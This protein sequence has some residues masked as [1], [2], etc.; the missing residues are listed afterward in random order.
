MSLQ[1]ILETVANFTIECPDGSI[2]CDKF[3]MI[4]TSSLIRNM[5]EEYENP[6]SVSVPVSKHSIEDAVKVIHGIASPQQICSTVEHCDTLLRALDFL[7]VD[8]P[9][10]FNRNDTY[11]HFCVLLRKQLPQTPKDALDYLS[12]YAHWF[13]ESHL[14]ATNFVNILSTRT[15]LFEDFKTVL[16]PLDIS[17]DMM[18]FLTRQFVARFPTVPVIEFFIRKIPLS[19][20]TTSTMIT[21]ATGYGSPGVYVHPSELFRIYQGISRSRKKLTDFSEDTWNL[22]SFAT[23]ATSHIAMGDP[24]GGPA[25]TGLNFPRAVPRATFVIEGDFHEYQFSVACMDEAL[26]FGINSNELFLVFDERIL[27]HRYKNIDVRISF[28]MKPSGDTR[29][30]REA[31]YHSKDLD[32]IYT[33][34]PAFPVNLSLSENFTR[35]TL[36]VNMWDTDSLRTT[37][38]EHGKDIDYIY[39]ALWA[40]E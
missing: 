6:E 26:H 33:E 23:D 16:K 35:S 3:I 27:H 9:A 28:V 38:E 29:E 21:V 24:D 14:L 2:R 20:R 18:S 8:H 19:R 22:L 10:E 17:I 25:I 13:M 36:G 39:L 11:S 37:W 15:R 5:Y 30:V 31:V 7:G 40:S 34:A 32:T 12:K 4:K 1:S